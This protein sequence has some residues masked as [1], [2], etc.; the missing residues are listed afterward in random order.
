MGR[1]VSQLVTKVDVGEVPE[2]LLRQAAASHP[3]VDP[4][5]LERDNDRDIERMGEKTSLLKQV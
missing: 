5:S 4:E 1:Y 3:G 2:V